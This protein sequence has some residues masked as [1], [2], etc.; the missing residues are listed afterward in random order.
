MVSTSA[1]EH[2]QVRAAARL[3]DRR[4]RADLSWRVLDRCV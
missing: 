2:L 1:V 3:D 4:T